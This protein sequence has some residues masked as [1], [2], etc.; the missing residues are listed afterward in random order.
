M[1]SNCDK[2]KEQIADLITGI[3][4]EKEAQTIEQHLN[5]CSVCRAY[6]QRM[7]KEEELLTGFFAKFD[8]NMTSREDESI[9]I[10]NRF[11]ASGQTNV[12]SLG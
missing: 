11:D 8:T 1:K 12:V 9:N 3:P 10:I 7:E 2:M 5:E 4:A 6:A